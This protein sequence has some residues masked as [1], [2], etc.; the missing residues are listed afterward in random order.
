MKRARHVG[1]SRK[2]KTC[3]K[4]LILN[5]MR[6]RIV[7]NTLYNQ[8]DKKDITHNLNEIEHGQTMCK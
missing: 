3:P 6:K 5:S 8:N 4:T 2:M 7:A 1:D